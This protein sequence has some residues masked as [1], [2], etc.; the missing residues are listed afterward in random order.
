MKKESREPREVL[1]DIKAVMLRKNKHEVWKLPNG[2]IITLSVT[3]RCTSA[4]RNQ[5]A[6]IKRLMNQPML[7]K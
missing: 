7:Q 3:P 6:D 2:A 1:K 5:I 4:K